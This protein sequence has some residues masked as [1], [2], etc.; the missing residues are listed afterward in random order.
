MNYPSAKPNLEGN[1]DVALKSPITLS[2]FAP[3]D[4]EQALKAILEY[5]NEKWRVFLHPT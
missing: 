3:I 5:P 1:L 4:S 2:E